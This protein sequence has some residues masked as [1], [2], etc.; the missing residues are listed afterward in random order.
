[1]DMRPRLML[2]PQ[3]WRRIPNAIEQNKHHAD[4]MLVSDGKKLVHSLKKPF[5]ILFPKQVMKEN[6]HT[7]KTELL[8][9]AQFAINGR[10]IPGF[11]LPGF[12]LVDRG[13]RR[14]IATY[15]PGL[16]CIPRIRL[17]DGPLAA[18]L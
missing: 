12:Q 7:G 5:V 11:R 6:P 8:R 3:L 13:T 1:M 18:W 4:V 17:L 9:P 16:L 15:K 10:R 2:L 14:K